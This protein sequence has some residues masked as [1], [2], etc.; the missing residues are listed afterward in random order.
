[1]KSAQD[2]FLKV[3]ELKREKRAIRKEYAD[4]LANEDEY[5]KIISEIRRLRV[6][7]AQIEAKAQ[8]AMGSRFARLE[9]VNSELVAQQEMLSDISIAN[10]VDGLAVE[11]TDEFENKYEPVFSVKMR[12]R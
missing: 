1:M 6:R 8:E 11:V 3:Q 12:K 10:L 2:V 4:V 9:E 5:T 7:K